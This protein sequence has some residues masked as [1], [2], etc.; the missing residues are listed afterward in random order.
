MKFEDYKY[1][2]PNLEIFSDH[3]SKEISI[4]NNSNT[5]S[6]EIASIK[7][8]FKLLDEV[9]AMRQLV[10]IR[11][12]LDSSNI[13]YQN[14]K[15]F[16]DKNLPF[17]EKQKQLLVE[18]MINSPNQKELRNEFGDYLF[19]KY[20]TLQKTFDSNIIDLLQ[21]E[22]QLCTKY[23]QIIANA[24]IEYKGSFYSLSQFRQFINSDNR[25]IR[26][27]AQLTASKW[28][29]NHE[30]Q[31]DEIYE[32]LV[33]LRTDIAKKLGYDNFVQLAYD[34]LG[35]LDYHANDVKL[36]RNHIFK[37]VIP[38]VN[39]LIQR[40]GE[41]LKIKKLKSYDL[42]LSFKNG[43]P[44]RIETSE[45]ILEQA[46]TMYQE[47]SENTEVFFTYLIE[48]NLLDLEPR[49]F[50]QSGGYCTYIPIFQSP[51]IVGNINGSSNDYIAITHEVGHAYQVYQS[52]NLI[53]DYRWPSYESAEICSMGM[54]FL[55]WPWL[56][57][58][59]DKDINKFKYKHLTD[60]IIF[61]PYCILV[62]EF[63]H[64]IYENPN[65]TMKERKDTWRRLEIKYLPYKDYDD[66]SFLNK[67]TFWYKQWHI[68]C[69]PF[70]YIDY[71]LGQIV[72]FQIWNESQTDYKKVFSKYQRLCKL[73]GSKP[74]LS[75]LKAA[76][77]QNP[78]LEK[79]I[80][81]TIEPII[82]FINSLSIE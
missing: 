64:I 24:K 37:Y 23:E 55:G 28:Y 18:K 35:R 82:K 22:N 43:N 1:K 65:M 59:F 75:L 74:Y 13:F 15:D 53:P 77:L 5:I 27:N 6:V 8:V 36:F 72:A 79:T 26:H 19:E 80:R 20:E 16:F 14:E 45:N 25:N 31:F 38:H 52:R 61:L 41:L 10:N 66:N 73:G 47:M 57:N 40:K 33:K 71:A 2:R 56:S 46:K 11:F 51:F 12:D 30:S 42:G 81:T 29:E 60:T 68:F 9:D 62:D 49:A 44:K 67:G 39:S 17:I 70:Y 63:Q 48:K 4:I 78:F 3:I 58:F 54:E 21:K 32:T 34:R 7:N 76:D 69:E 50:K